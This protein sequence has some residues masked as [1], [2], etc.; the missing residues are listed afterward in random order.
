MSKLTLDGVD[1]MGERLAEEV[2]SFVR[3]VVLPYILKLTKSFYFS[4]KKH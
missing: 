2:G 1:V 4:D 3:A